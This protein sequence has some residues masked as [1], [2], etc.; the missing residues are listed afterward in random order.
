MNNE[1][2]T[3]KQY[4]LQMFDSDEKRFRE[5]TRLDAHEMI[6]YDKLLAHL[7]LVHDENEQDKYDTNEKGKALEDIV[8]FLLEH[9]SIF[10]L[11]RNIRS[12]TN[13][14]DQLLILNSKGLG[15]QKA[16]LLNLYGEHFLSE[17]KNY[18]EKIGV[19]WIGKFFSLLQVTNARIGLLF[20]YHGLAGRHAWHSSLGLVK[21][22]FLLKERM[23]D[24]TYILDFNIKDFDKIAQGHGLLELIDAKIK[25]LKFDTD[26]SRYISKHPAEEDQISN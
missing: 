12:S 9:S 7:K 16:G 3:A 14:I 6:E 15:F 17:C 21:K 13:E 23:E 25:A 22:F 4:F 20:S 8:S 24:R 19:T 26:F 2:L 10:K 1:G 11:H 5:I 18:Q